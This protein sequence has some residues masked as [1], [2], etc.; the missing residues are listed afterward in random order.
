MNLHGVQVHFVITKYSSAPECK[1]L[2]KIK[3]DVHSICKKKVTATCNHK[4]QNTD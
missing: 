3:V 1:V 4:V 2:L